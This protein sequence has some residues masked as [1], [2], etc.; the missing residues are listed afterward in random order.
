MGGSGELVR[1]LFARYARG[2]RH[3]AAAMFAPDAV[4]SYR[5]RGPL[6]G[7]YRGRDAIRSFWSEQ[8]ARAGGVFMPT[9]LDL[10]ETDRRVFLLVQYGA[11]A[12]PWRRV[13]VYEIEAGLITAAQVFEGDPRGA[14]EHFHNSGPEGATR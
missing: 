1:E 9:L 14:A 7:E 12:H 6:Q 2:D 13:V 5:A 11:G 3:G 10:A 4:F 8:D